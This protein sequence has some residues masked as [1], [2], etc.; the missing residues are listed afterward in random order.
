[1]PLDSKQS[2]FILAL[3]ER[4]GLALTKRHQ[5]V[6]Q[7]IIEAVANGEP[8]LTG[9]ISDNE[10]KLLKS[11]SRQLD[12]LNVGLADLKRA[13]AALWGSLFWRSGLD[14]SVLPSLA[15]ELS[16]TL[17][18]HGRPG[19]K[20]DEALNRA[21]RRLERVYRAAGGQHTGVS[22]DLYDERTSKFI[23]FC[24]DVLNQA[25]GDHQFEFGALARRWERIR[26]EMKNEAQSD[27]YRLYVD[28]L[29]E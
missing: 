19:T 28:D 22:R 3:Q 8:A 25:P 14:L 15:Q 13:N 10:K 16:T 12:A 9:E 26:E 1:M 23:E 18:A 6:L 20:P 24:C 11:I 7:N 21:L 2:G 4:H 17:K 5:D 27:Y 29:S